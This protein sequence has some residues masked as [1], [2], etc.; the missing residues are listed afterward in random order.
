[1]LTDQAVINDNDSACVITFQA[2]KMPQ[3]W[4][5]SELLEVTQVP[6]TQIKSDNYGTLEQ[7]GEWMRFISVGEFDS[8]TLES[9]FVQIKAW[10]TKKDFVQQHSTTS[11]FTQK[12]DNR[13]QLPFSLDNIQHNFQEFLNK[14][15]TALPTESPLKQDNHNNYN[16]S[17]TNM[18]NKSNVYKK[19]YTK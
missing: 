6:Y 11:K 16:K 4:V 1:M 17:N 2:K 19:H 9:E 12:P 14:Y 18:Y 15:N 7:V 8:E 5:G 3:D 10:I 13:Q